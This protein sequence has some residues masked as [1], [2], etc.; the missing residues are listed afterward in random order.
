MGEFS[1]NLVTLVEEYKE[2]ERWDRIGK[3]EWQTQ[4][5]VWAAMQKQKQKRRLG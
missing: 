5:P 4:Q 1:P 2:R 3:R